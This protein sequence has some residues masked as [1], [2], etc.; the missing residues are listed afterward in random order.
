MG[1][2][3]VLLRFD[4]VRIANFPTCAFSQ[5]RIFCMGCPGAVTTRLAAPDWHYKTGTTRLAPLDWHRADALEP[6][7]SPERSDL[8]R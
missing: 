8:R 2:A 4:S 3:L 7:G 6:T 5:S 1:I